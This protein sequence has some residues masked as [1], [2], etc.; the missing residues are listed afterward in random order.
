M[1]WR[2]R[3]VLVL[4]SVGM[5]MG[6]AAQQI[7]F[8]EYAEGTANYKYL[9]IYNPTSAPVALSG[10]AFPRV[11]NAPTTPGTHEYWNTF[12]AGATIAPGD[13]YVICHPS[14]SAAV[15]AQC[16][17]HDSYLSNG[18]DGFCLVQGTEATHT[19]LDCVGDFNGDPGRAWDVCGVTE[20][21]RDHTL[22]RKPTVK[23][24]EE[25]HRMRR[26][27]ALKERAAARKVRQLTR[28]NSMSHQ[29]TQQQQAE[30]SFVNPKSSP[31]ADAVA[32]RDAPG[33]ERRRSSVA[34][35]TSENDER[36]LTHRDPLPQEAHRSPAESSS[37]RAVET[38]V[39]L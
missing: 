24:K 35:A 31:R 12:T 19:V 2:L 13:V 22:V 39:Y 21:T 4:L 27:A 36:F 7:F 6:A 11:V 3:L 38:S 34:A 30:E 16:D 9:E 1:R 33:K 14:A 37:T 17:Q 18:D 5:P 10:Y 29:Q 32:V 25:A 20:A 26:E 28:T 15:Q 8:S 23:E